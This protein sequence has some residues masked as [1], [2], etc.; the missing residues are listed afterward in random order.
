[1]AKITDSYQLRLKVQLDRTNAGA[2]KRA[3]ASSSPPTPPSTPTAAATN[4]ST[5]NLSSGSP[6]PPPTTSV[7]TALRVRRAR[8][9]WLNLVADGVLATRNVSD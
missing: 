7:P 1:M 5:R 4:G 6:S 8:V 3:S 2:A 9:V